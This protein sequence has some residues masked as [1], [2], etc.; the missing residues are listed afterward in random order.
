MD[1]PIKSVKD[2]VT[3]LKFANGSRVLSLPDSQKGVR[4]LTADLVII[5]EGSQVSDALY[6]S[7][8]PMVGARDGKILTLST[9][10][11]KR[12]WFY[13]EWEENK[14]ELTPW[15]RYKVICWECKWRPRAFFE[16]E[17]RKMGERWFGQEYLC[18]YNDTVDSVFAA[19]D[20]LR[21][22]SSDVQPLF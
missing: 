6:Y 1:Y 7:V 17:R 3:E 2:A 15:S 12:G 18:E 9:P 14:D 10:Y 13:N 19:D 4:G 5:D 22:M 20:I 16:E 11:G 21:A 8:R